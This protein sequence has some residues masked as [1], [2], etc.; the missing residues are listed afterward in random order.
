MNTEE[1]LTPDDYIRKLVSD[2]DYVGYLKVSAIQAL[3]DD[4]FDIAKW[5]AERLEV[6]Y[7]E[8]REARLALQR[9]EEFADRGRNDEQV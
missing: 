4:E 5:Y 6:I 7:E 1:N 9:I 2:D 8:D 3:V